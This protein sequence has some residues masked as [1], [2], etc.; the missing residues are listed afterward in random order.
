MVEKENLIR[1]WTIR[2]IMK[3]QKTVQL[4]AVALVFPEVGQSLDIT[5]TTNTN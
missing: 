1:K 3:S 5:V 2:S 4:T